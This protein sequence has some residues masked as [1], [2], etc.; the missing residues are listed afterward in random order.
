MKIANSIKEL[1]REQLEEML[2][3]VMHIDHEKA[4]M[5]SELEYKYEVMER[6]YEKAIEILIEC[7]LPCEMNDFMN[8][9]VDYCSMNCGVDE[10]VFKKCWRKYIRQEIGE[11][12]K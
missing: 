7:N 3:N 12:R 8:R 10:E 4:Q 1:S 6:E 11:E 2:V 9:N 5:I